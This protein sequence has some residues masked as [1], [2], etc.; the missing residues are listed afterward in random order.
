MHLL[1][2]KNQTKKTESFDYLFY[3]GNQ[4][5]L[6][7]REKRVCSKVEVVRIVTKLLIILLISAGLS[8]FLHHSVMTLSRISQASKSSEL[9]FT[10][11]KCFFVLS[12]SLK[13]NLCLKFH[14]CLRIFFKYL[15]LY[16]TI[17]VHW[18]VHQL[19]T[20]FKDQYS[21]WQILGAC[22]LVFK[23]LC[24][25]SA[26]CRNKSGGSG[27]PNLNMCLLFPYYRY[28]ILIMSVPKMSFNI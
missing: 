7:T 12:I 26:E 10:K 28:V 15:S 24:S 3:D 18:M 8:V 19:S 16:P 20:Y 2:T 23:T 13:L 9:I 11:V 5:N 22:S 25:D 6:A 14:Q 4:D 21:S 27:R 1:P 17:T